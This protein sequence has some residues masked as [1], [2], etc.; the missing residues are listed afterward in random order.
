MRICSD[1]DFL[2]TVICLCQHLTEYYNNVITLHTEPML[3]SMPCE[4]LLS[5]VAT[6]IIL[7]C[8]NRL[9]CRS[10]LFSMHR[11]W[12]LFLLFLLG[13]NISRSFRKLKMM[14]RCLWFG[15][16]L[17]PT[18]PSSNDNTRKGISFLSSSS[19]QVNSVLAHLS[20]LLF[21]QCLLIFSTLLLY[22]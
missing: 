5:Y 21:F 17:H 11:F 13:Y 3:H 2:V 10:I 16:A 22:K 18:A 19:F 1:W 9:K 14:E 4:L 6:A 20:L 12:P 7:Y 15:V 8:F